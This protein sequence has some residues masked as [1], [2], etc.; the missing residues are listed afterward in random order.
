M[1]KSRISCPPHHHRILYLN[2]FYEVFEKAFDECPKISRKVLFGD[3]NAKIG[4][5]VRSRL[6]QLLFCTASM[7]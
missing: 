2:D 4:K 3:F 7:R 5:V 1:L 6:D